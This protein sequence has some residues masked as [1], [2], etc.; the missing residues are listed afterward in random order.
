MRIYFDGCSW[1]WGSE[2]KQPWMSRYSKLICDRLGA[3]QYNISRKGAANARMVRQ[4]LV[5]HKNISEFDL[6][7]IQLTDPQ[8]Q[9]YYDKDRRKFASKNFAHVA[10]LSQEQLRH[11]G[12]PKRHREMVRDHEDELLPIDKAWLDYYRH[13]Y[14]EEYGD[15]YEDMHATAIRSFCKANDVPLILA[16]TKRKIDSKLSY[17]IY[18]GDVPRCAG[19]H[20]NE[21]GHAINAQQMIDYYEIIL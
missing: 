7:I 15:A 5:D 10:K 18:C 12:F 19:G 13:I 14:E 9:E 1:C 4:L 2:L 8:R 16:T 21:E 6:V 17:D 11:T 3:E 20:P